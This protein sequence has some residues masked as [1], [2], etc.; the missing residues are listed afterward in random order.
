MSGEWVCVVRV[1]QR[2]C[3]DTPP[4]CRCVMVREGGER[5]CMWRGW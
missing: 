3:C 2:V 1:G 5:V 4:H